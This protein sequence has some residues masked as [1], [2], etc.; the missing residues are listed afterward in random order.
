[1]TK[2]QNAVDKLVNKW[3]LDVCEGNKKLA[4]KESLIEA[5]EKGR[6]M[7]LEHLEE[8]IDKE[9]PKWD[10]EHEKLKRIRDKQIKQRIKQATLSERKRI[11]GEIEKELKRIP[12]GKAEEL[13]FVTLQAL[14]EKELGK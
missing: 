13:V 14:K 3:L 11:I 5:L 10:K 2:D 8:L 7:E 6:Q 1:M 9:R 12:L 4:L